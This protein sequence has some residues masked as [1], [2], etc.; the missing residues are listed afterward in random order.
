[1]LKSETVEAEKDALAHTFAHQWKKHASVQHSELREKMV[2]HLQHLFN[3]KSYR[4]LVYSNFHR[5]PVRKKVE[6]E[7]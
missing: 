3:L 2:L 5:M 1:M 7:N 6:K 4:F